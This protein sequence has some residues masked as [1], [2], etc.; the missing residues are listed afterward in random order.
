[1]ADDRPRRRRRDDGDSGPPRERRQR[2][3]EKRRPRE[4]LSGAQAARQARD[5]L[6][7]ITGLKPEAVTSLERSEDGGTWW[8]TVEL[9]ELSRVPETDDLLGSYEAELDESGEL[10]SYR[11]VRRYARSQ[12]QDQQFSGG[13]R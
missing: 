5:E 4:R 8:V 3:P 11:R 9:L 2:A 13:P 6:A 12:A 1:M 7:D 10:V